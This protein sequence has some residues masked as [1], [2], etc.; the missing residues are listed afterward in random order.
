MA[1][2]KVPARTAPKKHKKCWCVQKVWCLWRF[3]S[4]K[5]VCD[6]W[7]LDAFRRAPGPKDLNKN[8]PKVIVGSPTLDGGDV[9]NPIVQGYYT[10]N[11]MVPNDFIHKETRFLSRGLS[12]LP[13]WEADFEAGKRFPSL[14]PPK[15]RWCVSV[16]HVSQVAGCPSQDMI[17]ALADQYRWNLPKPCGGFHCHGGSPIAGWFIMKNPIYQWMMVGG[18]PI[19]GNFHMHLNP[20]KRIMFWGPV[21]SSGYDASLMRRTWVHTT[22]GQAGYSTPAV[23][24]MS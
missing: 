22:G 2:A 17:P 4:G 20:P 14:R 7:R 23:K 16:L 3:E 9:L 8:H 12:R 6:Q 15:H 1:P 24:G 13:H 19:S 10:P 18:T 21:L 11:S 5:S